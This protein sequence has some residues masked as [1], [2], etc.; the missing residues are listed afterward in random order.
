MFA[1]IGLTALLL[2]VR[3]VVNAGLTAFVVVAFGFHVIVAGSPSARVRL[4]YQVASTV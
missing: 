2:S 3:Y 1:I 4:Q